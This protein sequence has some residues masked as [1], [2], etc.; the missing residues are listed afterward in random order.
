[1]GGRDHLDKLV[2]QI[3]SRHPELLTQQEITSLR[4]CAGPA[5]VMRSAVLKIAPYIEVL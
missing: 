5:E 1:M 4:T 3:V 2:V